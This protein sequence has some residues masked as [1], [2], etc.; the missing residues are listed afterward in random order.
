M[1]NQANTGSKLPAKSVIANMKKFARYFS[2][3]CIQPLFFCSK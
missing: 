1:Q 2:K 3:A